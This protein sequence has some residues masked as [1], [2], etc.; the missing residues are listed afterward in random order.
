MQY[1][2]Q[3]EFKLCQIIKEQKE[4]TGGKMTGKEKISKKRNEPKTGARQR[5]PPDM[6]KPNEA[7]SWFFQS[8]IKPRKSSMGILA[9]LL[10]AGYN[11]PSQTV[12]F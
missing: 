9:K 10:P 7:K 3:A 2:L 6:K 5:K 8:S 11:S 12:F 4:K 1:L